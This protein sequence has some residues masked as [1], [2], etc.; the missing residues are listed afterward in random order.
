MPASLLVEMTEMQGHEKKRKKPACPAPCIGRWFCTP[1]SGDRHK[2]KN[3]AGQPKLGSAIQPRLMTVS[4][5]RHE[6]PVATVPTHRSPSV[7]SCWCRPCAVRQALGQPTMV[8]Q[9]REYHCSKQGSP[10]H[11][12]LFCVAFCPSWDCLL[13]HAFFLLVSLG[14]AKM[15]SVTH[16][17]VPRPATRLVKHRLETDVTI[18]QLLSILLGRHGYDAWLVQI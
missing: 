18:L 7:P 4:S 14:P 10:C 16:G 15:R 2:N 5:V 13:N 9:L 12:V 6:R 8:L 11:F 1:G 17:T 3:L